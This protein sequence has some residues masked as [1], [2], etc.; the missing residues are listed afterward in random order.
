MVARSD[1]GHQRLRQMGKDLISAALPHCLH[2]TDS[3]CSFIY[4]FFVL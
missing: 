3:R 1:K 4:V 2:G